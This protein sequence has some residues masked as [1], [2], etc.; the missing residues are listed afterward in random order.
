MVPFANLRAEIK[1]FAA[2]EIPR[3]EPAALFEQ[4]AGNH[5]SRAGYG[6]HPARSSH[7]GVIGGELFVQVFC[8]KTRQ[9]G[10]SQ[11]LDPIRA[12]VEQQRSCA[13]QAWHSPEGLEKGGDPIP[14]EYG[15]V[16]Q[17]EEVF[18]CGVPRSEV[19]GPSEAEILLLTKQGKAMGEQAVSQ[20]RA[21]GR[22]FIRGGIVHDYDFKK[23]ARGVLAQAF[24]ALFGQAPLVED[25]D[26]DGE[27]DAVRFR[28]GQDL[29][30]VGW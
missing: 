17:E 9:E 29:R 1:V 15:V 26:D 7:K 24:Q 13:P 8:L 23:I 4:T 18:A 19:A 20:I 11:V 5:K 25:R 2:V 16:V 3:K 14:C 6:L 30:R 28:H 12:R 10:H 22:G 27:K 21:L